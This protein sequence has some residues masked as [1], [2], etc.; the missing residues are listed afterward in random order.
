MLADLFI[1]IGCVL[2]AAGIY[3]RFVHSTAKVAVPPVVVPQPEPAPHTNPAPAAE[4]VVVPPPAPTDE[5][6]GFEFESWVADRF[7]SRS[8]DLKDW[9]S[10]K[11]TANGRYAKSARDPDLVIDL[12][13]GVNRFPFAVECK[14]RQHHNDGVVEL[15]KPG[16]LD[17]YR[18]YA[19]AEKRPVFIVLGVD[20][21]P[22]APTYLYIVPLTDMS[23]ATMSVAELKPY[24]QRMSRKDGFFFDRE[25]TVLKY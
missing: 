16:K 12:V 21:L 13:L 1:L 8:F 3:F 11:R 19:Q 6:K 15:A 20:G 2:L 23:S 10:D 14:W 7:P 24:M 9:R 5:Q 22:S 4:P 18:S 25:K 17:I